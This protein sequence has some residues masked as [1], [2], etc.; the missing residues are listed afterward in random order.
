MFL[1]LA[2]LFLYVLIAAGCA[3]VMFVQDFAAHRRWRNRLSTSYPFAYTLRDYVTLPFMW[4]VKVWGWIC[5]V[6]EA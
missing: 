3:A 6:G 1:L 2:I 5:E 4:P